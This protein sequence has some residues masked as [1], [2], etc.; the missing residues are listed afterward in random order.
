MHGR[1][2]KRTWLQKGTFIHYFISS[3][4][5]VRSIDINKQWVGGTCPA[6]GLFSTSVSEPPMW[7]LNDVDYVVYMKKK[8]ARGTNHFTAS[9]ESWMGV[10]SFIS[11]RALRV[12]N[13]SIRPFSG[14]YTTIP[15]VRKRVMD[16]VRLVTN[17]FFFLTAR[18][19]RTWNGPSYS[20]GSKLSK[21]EMTRPS[22]GW[23]KKRKEAIV[24]LPVSWT[25]IVI[26]SLIF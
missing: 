16:L 11:K 4:L 22:Y 10:D 13:K 19:E 14:R 17:C 20:Y 26:L 3:L 18:E 15:E 1:Q 7:F 5:T 23:N 9:Y 2:I 25:L 24:F 12:A 6:W 8:Q 21:Y